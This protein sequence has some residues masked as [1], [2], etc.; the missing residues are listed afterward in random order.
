[1]KI[2]LQYLSKYKKESL[3]VS[4]LQLL[5]WGMQTIT[6]LLMIRT[7]EYAIKLDGKMFFIYTCISILCWASYFYLNFI[8]SKSQGKLIIKLNSHVR[9]KMLSN[10]I[11]KGFYEFYS[12]DTGNYLSSLT[13][14]I[15]QI[16]TF[17][18]EPFFNGI[19]RMGQIMWS[20]IALAYL[21]WSLI[22]L[23]GI[24]LV[25]MFF[26]PKFFQ[27]KLEHLGEAF[28]TV[29]GK[30][31]SK[32]KEILLAFGV[33]K[34]FNKE[35]LF[36]S[37]G[38][39]YGQST[40]QINYE[41]NITKDKISLFLAFLNVLMQLLSDLLILWLVLKGRLSLAVLVG[42]SN[43]ISSVSNGFNEVNRSRLSIASCKSYFED[44]EN[45]I[46]NQKKEIKDFAIRE[47]IEVKN[48]TFS[49]SEKVVFRNLNIV[50]YIGKKHLILGRSGSGKSTLLKIL[51]G[52]F[53]YYD[54][55]ILYDGVDLRTIPG[56]HLNKDIGYIDQNLFLFNDSIKNNITL[57]DNYDDKK[58]S[59]SLYESSLNEDI[60]HMPDGIDTIVGENGNNISEGQKQ[61]VVIA[62]ALI[63]GKSI[64]FV[65][66]GT[67]SLDKENSL[68]IEKTLLNNKKLTLVYIAHSITNESLKK[69]DYIYDLDRM[70]VI[71]Q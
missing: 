28:S 16:E 53:D 27:N 10:L 62:R 32:F 61:R 20:L 37:L 40:E 51:L 42:G 21:D 43:L 22:R 2:I 33:F 70:M 14:N 68:R 26:V 60:E 7:F 38:N 50:F 13:T 8:L 35:N 1:M 47:R 6:Q 30:S 71:N 17:A 41:L 39:R 3:L 65:D 23:A 55:Q 4:F 52:W 57:Y 58:I 9:N 36:I 45:V 44:A 46:I 69:F 66:E 31:T 18:W 64:L 59:G 24:T 11:N 12:T 63:H 67:S 29:L 48:L 34:S 54:G 5:V 56:S 49:Y 19:G 15:K 25:I